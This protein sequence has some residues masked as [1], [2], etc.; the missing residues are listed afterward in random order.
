MVNAHKNKAMIIIL[1]APSGGGKS[2][3]AEKLLLQDSKLALSV[4]A[5]TRP[6][7]PDEK[8]SVH[9]FFKTKEEFNK[10]INSG[11]FLEH[12]EIYGNLYGTPSLYVEYMLAQG[13]D[14]L[15][16]IDSQGAYQIIKQ[17]KNRVVSIF[18]I[19]PDIKTL[20]TRLEA[21]N[22]D[23]NEVIEERIKLAKDEITHAKNYDY[24]VVN[25]NFDE[26][27]AEIQDI[28]NKERI[29]R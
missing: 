8:E 7:R 14:V 13:R 17:M 10:M 16:D 4:S 20:Q 27:V 11:D 19:P 26:A 3:I 25:D 18:I 21:R 15:F 1:S 29:K 23:S 22:Q 24:I 2:S 6:A 12:A 9:Y 28:I 5:T